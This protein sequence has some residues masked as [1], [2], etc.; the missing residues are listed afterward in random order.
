MNLFMGNSNALT[1]REAVL[2]E[3]L[4]DREDE[5]RRADWLQSDFAAS[6]WHCQFGTHAAYDVDFRVKVDNGALLT[7]PQHT[8]L[9]ETFKCWLICQ[10]HRDTN[11]GRSLHWAA[12]NDWVRDT[13]QIID[14]LLLNARRLG[15]SEFGL[16]CLTESDFRCLLQDLSQFSR[17]QFSI[18]LWPQR[19]SEYLK[20]N[21]TK[22]DDDFVEA[23]LVRHPWIGEEIL[24]RN[25][26]ELNLSDEE[27]IRARVWLWSNGFYKSATDDHSVSLQFKYQ[28]KTTSLASLIYADTL[29]G[30]TAKS[31]VI[32]LM[33]VPIERY[34][35]EFQA[36]PVSD[37]EDDR[38]S[39]RLL[40]RYFRIIMSLETLKEL[41]LP[42]PIS[43]LDAMS[44]GNFKDSLSAK[45]G[46]RFKTLP[47]NVALNALE[48]AI[49]Y[50]IR[51]GDAIV[52]S[53]L[54]F[55]EKNLKDVAE[56]DYR[57]STL[58]GGVSGGRHTIRWSVQHF[59]TR[60]QHNPKKKSQSEL[61]RRAVHQRIREHEG[62]HELLI[63]LFGATVICVGTVMARRQHELLALKPG[64]CID[65]TGTFLIFEKGKSGINGKRVMEARPIP[66]IGVRAI[67]L[68]ERLHAGLDELKI[69]DKKD[70]LF[71]YLKM[72]ATGLVRANVTTFNQAL[73]MFCD[74]SQS[75]LDAEGRRYYIRQHQL[76]RFFAMAFFW[77]GS[78]GGMDMLRWFLGHTDVEHLYH[79]I[80]ETTP[81]EVLRGVKVQYA[82]EAVIVNTDETLELAALLQRRFG[83]SAFSV[84]DSE[85][86]DQYIEELMI[87]GQVEVEPVFF[88]TLQ[89]RSYRI[90]VKVT[91]LECWNGGR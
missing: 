54:L 1:E 90:V 37:K 28:I 19:L 55:V 53:T 80:T 42:V 7:S 56:D 74:Y 21:I 61:Q 25:E 17:K 79:Y 44:N 73:T 47:M 72:D 48:A 85:E 71:A 60:V 77:A 76:R 8:M 32:D 9:L 51:Y 57:Y 91:K 27:L 16:E 83:I 59:M 30:Q 43:A 6:V 69:T 78:F 86:L 23:I 64:R 75:A 45:S 26:R 63:I 33:L 46:K 39:S 50:I 38:V 41:S 68:L 65:K 4:G 70:S 5:Y 40:S 35:T 82:R 18:Y 81:G 3:A 66:P 84:L 29:R 2:F 52:D 87:A 22:M 15:I 13:L 34:R 10:T 11:G 49:E 36:S 20:A 58:P 88:E 14:Y 12:A 62:L 89:G 67:R 24:P 31:Q